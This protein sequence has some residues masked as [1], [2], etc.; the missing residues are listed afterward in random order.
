MSIR[1]ENIIVPAPIFGI[2][3]PPHHRKLDLVAVENIKRSIKRI[4]LLHPLICCYDPHTKE[5]V[6]IDGHHRLEALKELH[7][8][9]LLPNA[10]VDVIIDEKASQREARIK[11]LSANVHRADLTALQRADAIA[12]LLKYAGLETITASGEAADTDDGGNSGQVAQKELK[13][14]GR[15]Q[16]P[17]SRAIKKTGIERREAGRAKKVAELSEE[18]KK[19][20][21]ELGLDDNQKALLAAAKFATPEEQVASLEATAEAKEAGPKIRRPIYSADDTSN[22]CT[23][24]V[25]TAHS[26]LVNIVAEKAFG[27]EGFQKPLTAVIIP[28]FSSQYSPASLGNWGRNT[29]TDMFTIASKFLQ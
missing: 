25:S 9:G 13:Q 4:G 29:P 6:L 12:E 22:A 8:E 1:S 2:N 3:I 21:A 16:S 14:R 15:K 28:E 20:A 18:A 5:L 7:V 17:K 26:Q 24:L 10:M 11:S 19:R 23:E 27:D